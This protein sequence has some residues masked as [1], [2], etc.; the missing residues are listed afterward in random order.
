[1]N[2]EDNMQTWKKFLSNNNKLFNYTPARRESGVYRDPH[3]RSSIRP[4][5]RPSHF[6]F[7]D[8]N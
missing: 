5:I 2:S 8:N 6:W 4:S 3:V 1:M 7:P